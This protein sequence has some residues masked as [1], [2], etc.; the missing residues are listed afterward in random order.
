M[1]GHLVSWS[2]GRLCQVSEWKQ[3]LRECAC[4]MKMKEDGLWQKKRAAVGVA[5]LTDA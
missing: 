2:I 3:N 1:V 5:D 4:W